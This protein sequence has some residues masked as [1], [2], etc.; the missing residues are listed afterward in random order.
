[1]VRRKPL[2]GPRKVAKAQVE[3]VAPMAQ[4][5]E[6][7]PQAE[8]LPEETKEE[9]IKVVRKPVL[10]LQEFV[11]SYK[12]FKPHHLPSIVSFFQTKG[13]ALRGTEEQL[14]GAMEVFGWK[15]DLRV[16]PR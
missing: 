13:Y 4:I 1:M 9:P 2:I 15:K 12:N 7:E 16:K 8:I 6:P 10:M 14:E 5:E 11:R 3:E